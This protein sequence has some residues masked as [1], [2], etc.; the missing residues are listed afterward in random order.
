MRG[1]GHSMT[2]STGT[3]IRMLEAHIYVAAM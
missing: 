3:L 2:D 1:R